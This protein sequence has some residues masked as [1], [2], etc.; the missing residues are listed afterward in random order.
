[1]HTIETEYA[2]TLK[3]KDAQTNN[4]TIEHD[5]AID[6]EVTLEKMFSDEAV[7]TFRMQWTS[8]EEDNNHRPYER[9]CHNTGWWGERGDLVSAKMYSWLIELTN[10]AKELAEFQN[11]HVHGYTATVSGLVHSVP[12]MMK[13]K[14]RVKYSSLWLMGRILRSQNRFGSLFKT[15]QTL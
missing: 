7:I 9:M 13:G 10:N 14:I 12:V 4:Y 6:Y 15:I 5:A 1:M 2:K 3:I 8:K 11:M